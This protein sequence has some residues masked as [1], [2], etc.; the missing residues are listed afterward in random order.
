MEKETQKRHMVY[1]DADQSVT[2]LLAGHVSDT[3]VDTWANIAGITHPPVTDSR[4][5]MNMTQ[6]VGDE[7][8]RRTFGLTWNT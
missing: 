5:D 6:M 4:M 1:K 8:G 2:S 7:V 3:E